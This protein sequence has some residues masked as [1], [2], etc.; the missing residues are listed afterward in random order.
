M[1]QK[2][3]LQTKFP[4][5]FSFPD[6]YPHISLRPDANVNIHTLFFSLTHENNF[7]FCLLA[8]LEIIITKWRFNTCVSLCIYYHNPS[9]FFPISLCLVINLKINILVALF[10]IFMF[11]QEFSFLI[12]NPLKIF[13]THKYSYGHLGISIW[14]FINIIF[15]TIDEVKPSWK[16]Y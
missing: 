11:S 14:Y 16:S 13:P 8:W 10:F 7:I 2:K 12:L 1:I 9:S 15:F 6:Q 3:I 5:Q 4:S